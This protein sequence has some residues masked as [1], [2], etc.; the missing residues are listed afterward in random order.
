M[1]EQNVKQWSLPVAVK[2][3]QSIIQLYCNE[4][5]N[6]LHESNNTEREITIWKCFSLIETGMNLIKRSR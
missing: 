5:T 3:T 2:Y 6:K 4:L 1:Y